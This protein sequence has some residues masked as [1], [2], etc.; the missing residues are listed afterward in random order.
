[1]GARRAVAHVEGC[2]ARGAFS[3]G[4]HLANKVRGVAAGLHVLG[5]AGHVAR[6]DIR[7]AGRGQALTMRATDGL[8]KG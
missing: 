4:P 5:N 3:E 1:M 6:H 2:R 8:R 7:L